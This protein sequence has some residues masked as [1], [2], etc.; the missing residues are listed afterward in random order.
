MKN[1]HVMIDLETLDTQSTA[2]VVA[3]GIVA[4]TMKGAIPGSFYCRLNI[5]DQL[6]SGRTVSGSTLSWWIAQSDEARKQNFSGPAAKLIEGLRMCSDFIQ[7]VDPEGVWGN[8]ASFDNAILSS[9]FQ[10]QS[11]L[12]PWAFYKDRCYRTLSSLYPSIKRVQGG[13]H[14]NALDDANSQVSHLL[15]MIGNP[16][17]YSPGG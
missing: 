10:S 11:L 1:T 9:L 14:H 5:D 6:V 3:I 13:T 15:Q 7:H 4:F 16:H 2:V 8:G 12:V 17:L